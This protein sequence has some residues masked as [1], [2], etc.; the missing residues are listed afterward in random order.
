MTGGGPDG[1]G[2]LSA[3]ELFARVVV[4]AA[5]DCVIGMDP[6]GRVVEF[7]PAAERT[8]GYRREEAVGRE[9]AELI[10]P[11]S[12]VERHRT[13]LR[14][15][16]ET[17]QSRI[18]G[19]RMQMPARRADGSELEVELIVV[20]APHDG[21]AARYVAYLR[22]LTEQRRVEQALRESEARFRSVVEDQTEL[23]CRYD[24]DFRL[25]FCNT[26]HARLWDVPAEA[27]AGRSLFN[28]VPER[29]R[30]SLR[31]QLEALT[32][33]NPVIYGENEKTLPGGEVRWYEWMNRALFDEQGR[34]TGYQSVGRDVTERRRAQDELARHREALAQSERMAAF[35][36]LLAGVAHEL[37]NP[38]SVV[39]TQAVLLLE[40]ATQ[41]SVIQRAERIRVAADRCGRIVRSFLAIAR[42]KPPVRLPV[43]LDEVVRSALELTG[44]GL[45]SAG[46]AVELRVPEDLPPI[47]GDADQLG[48]LAMNLVVNAQQ[49]MRDQPGRRRLLVAAQPAGETVRLIVEDNGPGVPA[50]IRSRIFDPFFTTKER[51]SGT[52]LGLSLCLGIAQAHGG[53][54]AIEDV[55][56]GGARF[57]V[58][59]AVGEGVAP[60]TEERGREAVATGVRILIVDDEPELAEGLAE[61]LG[62]LADRVDVAANGAEALRKAEAVPYDLVVSD[63]RMPELDGPG[64][65]RALVGRPGG[66]AGRFIVVTG[67]TLDR[68]L[69][70]FIAQSGVTVLE[71]PFTPDDARRAVA[72]ALAQPPLPSSKT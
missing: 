57:V 40:Q 4:D 58:T 69:E 1:D 71:K 30:A 35:G 8:F 3:R 59:L 52:G 49:A 39:L 26:A 63:L 28:S 17:G 70:T 24:A 50:A 51:G 2:E 18:L 47:W 64:L 34:R 65:Y 16:V 33:A 54:I 61:A 60:P 45:K 41:P 21:L 56:G 20:E 13:S 53:S 48:Q 46:I 29:L 31:G 37:N 9:I 12:M 10:V 55:P 15:H 36:S 5:L 11:A 42:A 27:L 22:D 19:R 14:R 43:R 72:S 44:Y 32:P 25:V 38:L 7:N 68:S 6:D 62:A 66:F 23:I 67:D